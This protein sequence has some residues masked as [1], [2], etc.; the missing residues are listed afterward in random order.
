[1]APNLH[2]VITAAGDSRTQFLAAGFNSPKSLLRVNGKNVLVRAISSYAIDPASTTVAVNRQEDDAW[3][4]RGMLA[5]ETP[6]VKVVSV[7]TGVQGALISALWA[8]ESIDEGAELVVCAGDSEIDF[9]LEEVL[10]DFQGASVDAGT[11]VFPSTDPRWSYVLPGAANSIR[12]VA[13]KRV[14]GPL[15]TTGIFYFRECSTF[16]AAAEWCLVNNANHH[17]NFY[18]STTLNFLISESMNVQYREIAPECY[19]TWSLPAD[20]ATTIG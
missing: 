16:K 8:S 11:V 1:M 10:K 20:F 2:T 14:I 19:R 13:E 18:V 4:I 7:P 17:G 15:A 12:Q 6:G 9:S 3:N 5:I